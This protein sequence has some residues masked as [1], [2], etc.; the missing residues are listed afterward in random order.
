MKSLAQQYVPPDKD[1]L[2]QAYQQ[3]NITMGPVPGESQCR[4]ARH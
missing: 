4:K 2:Q 1:M 3:G